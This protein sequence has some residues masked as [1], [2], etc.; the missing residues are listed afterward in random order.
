MYSSEFFPAESQYALSQRKDSIPTVEGDTA[1]GEV[2]GPSSTTDAA[3]RRLRTSSSTSVVSAHTSDIADG[4]PTTTSTSTSNKK[5]LINNENENRHSKGKEVIRPEMMSLICTY[6]CIFLHENLTLDFAELGHLTLSIDAPAHIQSILQK[7]PLARRRRYGLQTV[8]FDVTN[9]GNDTTRAANGNGNNNNND[10]IKDVDKKT[11]QE[12]KES[13]MDASNVNNAKEGVVQDDT[14]IVS[15][16]DG[17]HGSD[18]VATDSATIH[19]DVDMNG[20]SD[21]NQAAD[22]ENN[23]ERTSVNDQ[24]EK[25]FDPSSATPA[26]TNDQQNNDD[27]DSAESDLMFASIH[28]SVMTSMCISLTLLDVSHLLCRKY[29]G[30]YPTDLIMSDN[31]H[32]HR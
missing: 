23:Q 28:L 1:G 18:V 32:H 5:S 15:I 11:E 25:I 17:T 24:Y 6:L 31:Y 8:H 30:R 10:D 21:K 2:A 9:V 14:G 22:S 4:T 13:I 27:D 7:C 20:D 12:R 29:L 3:E 16:T 26:L 19:V